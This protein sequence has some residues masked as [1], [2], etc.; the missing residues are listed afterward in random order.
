VLT[1][2]GRLVELVPA[3]IWSGRLVT[4]VGPD[5]QQVIPRP[6]DELPAG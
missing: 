1:A 2:A 4:T 6:P 5:T 3:A